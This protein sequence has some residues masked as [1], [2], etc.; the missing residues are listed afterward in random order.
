[1]FNLF[2]G[3]RFEMYPDEICVNH[4]LPGWGF[5]GNQTCR[6]RSRYDWNMF[7]SMLVSLKRKFTFDLMA[8]L[9]STMKSPKMSLKR[10]SF[11]WWNE[12][13]WSQCP[14]TNLHVVLSFDTLFFPPARGLNGM[15]PTFCWWFSDLIHS[16]LAAD[17][18]DLHF[19]A[20]SPSGLLITSGSLPSLVIKLIPSTTNSCPS[21]QKVS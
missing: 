11:L 9:V 21:L 14:T 4:L 17:R 5:T 6:N 13:K 18:L 16:S 12:R 2:E 15:W 1:M 19:H 3:I 20:H 8:I 7:I 10:M